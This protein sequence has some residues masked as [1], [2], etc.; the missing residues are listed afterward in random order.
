M[1]PHY[2]N[3]RFRHK[4]QRVFRCNDAGYGYGRVADPSVFLIADD[5]HRID[6]DTR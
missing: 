5:Y 3:S 6:D 2:W 1:P 4:D